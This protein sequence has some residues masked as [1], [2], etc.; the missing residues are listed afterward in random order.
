MNPLR[1]HTDQRIIKGSVAL[2]LV[3]I[4]IAAVFYRQ[5]SE[6]ITDCAFQHITGLSCPGCGLT[7]SFHSTTMFHFREAFGF[8]LLG[9]FFLLGF[10]LIAIVYGFEAITGKNVNV[11]I[12]PRF[13]KISLYSL[14][15]IWLLYWL[16]RMWYEIHGH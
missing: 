4:I 7:R 10:L 12:A 3:A 14:A 11:R 6:T 5:G 13:R 1:L 16:I 9:P 2:L 15:G 8:H